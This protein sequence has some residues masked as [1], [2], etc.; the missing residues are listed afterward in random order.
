MNRY[1]RIK[2]LFI[3]FIIICLSGCGGSGSEQSPTTNNQSQQT[4]QANNNNSHNPTDD[5]NV[6]AEP[7][8]NDDSTGN[9][10]VDQSP[11]L[12]D[13]TF[14]SQAKVSRFLQ[15]ATFG[16]T[17]TLLSELDN[18]SASQ[19]YL[20]QL[21][22]TPSLILPSVEAQAP[23]DPED[24]FNLFYIEQTSFAFWRNSIG[25]PDQLR[26]RAAFAL[27]EILVV[28][29]GGGEVLT[30]VPEAVAAYQD[31]LINNAFGN[32]RT[33]LERVTY[34][35]AMGHYLTYMGSEK[36]NDETGRMPDENYARELLQLFTLGVVT[37][38]KDGSEQLDSN[39]NT[40]ELYDNSD[41]TGLARVFTGLNL[42]EDD[43]EAFLGKR[44]SV[45]MSVF[46]ESHSEK[47]KSFLG[48]TIAAGTDAPTSI[49]EALDHIFNHQN[50]APFVTK[51]LIQRLITS[52]PSPDYVQ[53]VVT[54]FESGNFTLPDGRE[55]G[56][57][58][59][60]DLSATFAAILFDQEARV[61]NPQTGGKIREPILRF[62]QW[63]RAFELTNITPEFVPQLWDTSA[64]ADLAQHPY[65]SPSVFNFFRP[66][67][68]APG[69]VTASNGLVSPELQIINASSIPGYINFMTYFITGQQ[70]EADLEELKEEF[71]EIGTDL[72]LDQALLS[73]KPNYARLLSVANDPTALIDQLN[74]LLCANQ[75][76]DQTQQSI[77]Q[78]IGFI[79]EDEE[80]G[81][82][83]RVHLSI[84]MVM[85]SPDYLVQK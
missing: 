55:V 24:E 85:S 70:Q 57:N 59:R 45:P 23:S 21:K 18:K 6:V 73:F 39:G 74:L 46:A 30:D 4:N 47:E 71:D 8:D 37:L 53:R 48:H 56:A 15:Q 32:Y 58:Q 36:G 14:S 35:P 38:N 1:I 11:T 5:N 40:I 22:V 77:K 80:D 84:L 82:L 60:G 27:S 62:T 79:E 20:S 25:A 78:V 52:N 64:S 44:F 66:G 42:N 16:A 41:I 10:D 76:S 75:L 2:A 50:L 81:F 29:N 67:Y 31:I 26:Q 83:D 72:N 68:K 3:T 19:W 12:T 51:Q 28:S 63:A 7:N 61:P 43:P 54:A 69:S 49:S 9:D 33:L 65:R 13:T 34:S 17:P